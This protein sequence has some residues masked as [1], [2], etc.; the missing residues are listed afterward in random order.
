MADGDESATDSFERMITAPLARVD[1]D[2]QRALGAPA[3]PHGKRLSTVE[4]ATA[5]AEMRYQAAFYA[6]A[7]QAMMDG[8][9]LG[10]E[11]VQDKRLDMLEAGPTTDGQDV[12]LAVVMTLILEGTIGPAIASLATAGVIRPF[13]R[14]MAKGMR[15]QEARKLGRMA[16]TARLF[17]ED[18]QYAR[19]LGNAAAGHA[20][21]LEQKTLARELDAAADHLSEL[22]RGKVGAVSR[23]FKATRSALVAATSFT[24][25][26]LVAA[27]KIYGAVK[28]T[29]GTPVPVPTGTPAGVELRAAAMASAADLRLALA[30]TVESLE[31]LIR[32]PSVK[33]TD[34]KSLLDD[35]RAEVDIDIAV[36]RATF[37]LATEALIWSHLYVTD[38]SL[39]RTP[40]GYN[41]ESTIPDPSQLLLTLNLDDKLKKYLLVRFGDE[42]GW[43]AVEKASIPKTAL[44]IHGI[45]GSATE[46]DRREQ[47]GAPR[48]TGWWEGLSEPVQF[49][50]LVQYLAAVKK[51]SLPA[52]KIYD[53]AGPKAGPA[54]SAQ[55]K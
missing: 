38:E 3:D 13:M 2:R 6:E 44:Y 22:V 51:S 50:F 5:V 17:R 10:A 27:V 8:V 43:W 1:A 40:P 4:V 42:A 23:D 32:D 47:P 37:H 18:A 28:S 20:A 26:N 9:T 31:I 39:D 21:R 41:E 19:S 30:A 11:Q 24:R 55:P 29:P 34:V 48:P 15:G 14:M 54:G 46:G 52:I 7:I 33:A 45:S 12:F 49:D 25:D 16:G 36:I 53:R 35:F